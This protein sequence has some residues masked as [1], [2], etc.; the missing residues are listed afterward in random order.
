MPAVDRVVGQHVAVVLGHRY[1]VEVISHRVGHRI[2]LSAAQMTAH[3]Y[4]AKMTVPIAVP[5]QITGVSGLAIT[6]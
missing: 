6:A 2:P 1:P 4:R 3:A 5:E